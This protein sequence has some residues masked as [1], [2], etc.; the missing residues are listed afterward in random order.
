ML[1][2]LNLHILRKQECT[3]KENRDAGD[4]LTYGF[5]TPDRVEYTIQ[6]NQLK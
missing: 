1:V 4:K 2:R 6:S 3:N 5:S